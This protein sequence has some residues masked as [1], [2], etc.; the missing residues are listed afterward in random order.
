LHWGHRG[1]TFGSVNTAAT[2]MMDDVV[3][4]GETSQSPS[5]QTHID[6]ETDF[7]SEFL[8]HQTLACSA[9]FPRRGGGRGRLRTSYGRSTSP[10]SQSQATPLYK[11]QGPNWTEA[12][13]LVLIAQTHVEWDGRHNSNQPSLAKF[14]YGTT[15]WKL[16]F[17]GVHGCGGFLGEGCR[18][19]N[20]QVG[21]F[22]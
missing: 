14:V 13:M 16:V 12:E 2:S 1:T 7:G 3:D 8:D 9:P 15:A 20:K 11:V 18:S 10:P 21:W 19:N 22:D 6:V 4:L 5:S 17:A